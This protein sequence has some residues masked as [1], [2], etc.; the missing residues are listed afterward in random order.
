MSISAAAH[1]PHAAHRVVF[2][3]TA[4]QY[5]PLWARNTL[6]ML[7]T[8]SLSLPWAM[9]SKF[10]YFYGHTQVA[11]R[12]LG[13]HAAPFSMFV[14]NV[15]GT[16]CLNLLYY[17][18]SKT[19]DFAPYGV[20]T[21]QLLMAA[22]LPL[23]LRGM[24]RF[25]LAHT[26]WGEH[27]FRFEGSVASAYRVMGLPTLLY[28]ASGAAL[29]KA[30]LTLQ[31]CD[32]PSACLWAVAGLSGLCISLPAV[33]ATFK[34]YQARHVRW[35]DASLGQDLK[36]DDARPW[37]WH[38]IAAI[39][40]RAALAALLVV[41]AVLLPLSW[42]MAHLF[43]L[44]MHCGSHGLTLNAWPGWAW[45]LLL[46]G[47]SW[48][49]LAMIMAVPYALLGVQVHT[50]LLPTMAGVI[51]VDCHIHSGAH[52]RLMMKRWWHVWI[53]AGFRYPEAVVAD[54][55]QRLAGVRVWMPRAD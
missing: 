10:K 29:V 54:V 36:V 3:G 16:V 11:G 14:G 45:S 40:W 49:G 13:F 6:L 21:V 31:R 18:I 50:R 25:Q 37:P 52:L 30:Y 34:A 38:A 26:S 41:F 46:G 27:R 28:I 48:V 2:T 15:L 7:L 53:T 42:A 1:P 51:Q 20:A 44:D 43:G 5:R 33:Y 23:M 47:L 12:S 19:G 39:T 8:L 22:S 4:A 9:V 17:G 35:G 32:T 55:S 24:T